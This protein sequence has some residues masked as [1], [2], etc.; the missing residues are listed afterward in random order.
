MNVD[1][2]ER[3]RD[4]RGERERRCRWRGLKDDGSGSEALCGMKKVEL[5]E[6][7]LMQELVLEVVV[8]VE[9]I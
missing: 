9:L 3:C 5:V 8:Q 6:E 2:R 4:C 7:E 1:G